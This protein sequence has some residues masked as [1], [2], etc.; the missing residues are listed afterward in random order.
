MKSVLP[1]IA[2]P[3]KNDP[4]SAI[5][6]KLEQAIKAMKQAAIDEV[7]NEISVKLNLKAF[8]QSETL[9]L[10]NSRDNRTFFGLPQKRFRNLRCDYQECC[11]ALKHHQLWHYY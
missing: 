6:A 4:M 7:K 5:S 1:S 10:H 2:E 11:R 3:P 8:S 9:E